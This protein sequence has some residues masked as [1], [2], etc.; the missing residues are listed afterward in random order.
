ME[1]RKISLF[2]L[3]VRNKPHCVMPYLSSIVSELRREYGRY[4]WTMAFT[5]LSVAISAIS[6][7]SSIWAVVIAYR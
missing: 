7:V 2:A 5:A 1:D 3:S 6:L 4:W